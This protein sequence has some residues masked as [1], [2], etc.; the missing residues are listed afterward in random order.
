MW[1]TESSESR[2][3]EDVSLIFHEK[4]LH[5]LASGWKKTRCCWVVHKSEAKVLH[6]ECPNA[7]S[8]SNVDGVLGIGIEGFGEH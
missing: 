4:I 6:W 7:L 2:V 5:V 1:K 8:S 3:E